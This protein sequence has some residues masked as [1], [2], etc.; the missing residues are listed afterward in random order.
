[1]EI[2]ILLTRKEIH[3]GARDANQVGVMVTLTARSPR[4]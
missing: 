1:V 2:Q 4:L 3:R